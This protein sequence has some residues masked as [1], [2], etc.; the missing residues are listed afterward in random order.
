[1]GPTEKKASVLLDKKLLVFM[2]Q[3]ELLEEK[4]EK[5]NSLIEQGWFFMSKARYSMG[6]KQVSALQYGNEMEPLV[7]VNTRRLE[8]GEAAFQT[9]RN[10]QTTPEEKPLAEKLVEDIGPKDTEGLRRRTQAKKVL[11]TEEGGRSATETE[12]L[13]ESD[14]MKPPPSSKLEHNPQQNPLRWFGVLVP[15][16]LKQAQVS[17][18]QVIE[19]S[20]EVAAL[21]SAVLATRKQL[22]QQMMEKN[23][24]QT[25]GQ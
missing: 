16:T 2:D 12:L 14:D 20:A 5:L 6:N 21:Q 25:E 18:R 19:L 7:R 3:L 4:R 9:D 15:Q 10:T 8:S 1:M 11:T 22:Q 17:F 23:G 13:R 24:P